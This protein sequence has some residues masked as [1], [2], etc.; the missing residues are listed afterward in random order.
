[1]HITEH[2]TGTRQRKIAHWSITLDHQDYLRLNG[3]VVMSEREIPLADGC[4]TRI[5]TTSAIE[6]LYEGM[7][8][9]ESGSTY[10]LLAP[11][12]RF[13]AWLAANNLQLRSTIDL[14]A[15]AQLL[16]SK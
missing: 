3:V 9:T 6:T 5:T 2:R 1:M 10:E 12:E 8:T 15:V 4:N 7:I 16:R 14:V 11:G 13:A